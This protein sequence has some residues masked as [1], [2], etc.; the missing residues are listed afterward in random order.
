ML[1]GS[2]GGGGVNLPEKWFLRPGFLRQTQRGKAFEMRLL[3]QIFLVSV[4][5]I[6]CHPLGCSVNQRVANTASWPL[7]PVFN[8]MIAQLC[9]TIFKRESSSE[10]YIKVM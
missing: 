8:P 9:R 7:E 2:G 5:G 10:I 1:W 6:T 4:Q 3:L